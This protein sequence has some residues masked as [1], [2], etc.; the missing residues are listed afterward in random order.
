MGLGPG[1]PVAQDPTG[2][3][4]L[5]VDGSTDPAHQPK[6]RMLI[7]KTIERLLRRRDIT[8]AS[9]PLAIQDHLRFLDRECEQ[10]SVG[11]D[12]VA[13]ASATGRPQHFQGSGPTLPIRGMPESPRRNSRP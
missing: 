11:S 7:V 8:D 2:A 3:V 13:D 4:V 10:R 6:G 1:V 5:L 9:S 12:D